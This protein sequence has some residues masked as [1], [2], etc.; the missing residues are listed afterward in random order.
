MAH[1]LGSSV[2]I[3]W[4]FSWAY[5]KGMAEEDAHL[6]LVGR[7]RVGGMESS[8]PLQGYIFLSVDVLI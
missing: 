4:L 7:E 8:H 6:V 3:N 1:S 5:G 2:I